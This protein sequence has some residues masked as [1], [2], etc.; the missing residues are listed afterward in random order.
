MSRK[1]SASTALR[2]AATERATVARNVPVSTGSVVGERT[3]IIIDETWQVVPA[4]GRDVA[5]RVVNAARAADPIFSDGDQRRAQTI[6]VQR[7]KNLEYL[8][9]FTAGCG[10]GGGSS[11]KLA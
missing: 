11:D 3:V 8:R 10:P 5:D 4:D 9:A 1:T 7:A 6:A 2:Q